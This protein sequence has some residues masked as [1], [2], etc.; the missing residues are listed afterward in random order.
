VR[1]VVLTG[2]V[3]LW[4][5][6]TV[7]AEDWT[8]F[9]G[10]DRSGISTATGLMRTFPEGG[11][12][13][14]WTA[15]VCQGYAGPAVFAGEVYFNDYDEKTSVW[16]VRCLSLTDGQEQWRFKEPREIRANHGIT[17]TVPA[18]DGK[19]VFSLDP[20]CGFHCL[21]ASNGLELWSKNLVEEYKAKIP[22]WYNGQCP[23]IEPDR[24]L[25]ATGGDALAVAFEKAT[26][27]EIWRTPNPD[28]SPMSHVSLMPAEIGGVKQY[29]YCTLKAIMGISAADGKLLWS[30]PWKFNL[31]VTPSPVAIGD[32][33]VF[34]TSLYN[35]DSVMIR[36]K[37][38]GD[39]WD[40]EK[41]F[42]LT[43]SEWN[44]EVHTP[45][46][47]KDRLFAVGKKSRGLFT[48]L[49]LDGKIVWTS[50]GKGT[51]GLGSFLL[52]DG[53]FFVLDG[54]TGM[55]RLFEAST[56]ECK[57]LAHAQVLS[58]GDVWAPMALSDGKLVLR[59]MKKM[60]CVE[61][62]AA[63]ASAQR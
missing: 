9:R 26:G 18:V 57:E 25:I 32:G 21:E 27:K 10:P 62:K 14:L 29:L 35:A 8:Q 2:F 45:I 40:V 36:V 56:T 41:V 58:G 33:R 54:D 49:D 28:K 52:A 6:T 50:E 48:C 38:E 3:L 30:F 11:P 23:L 44:A 13:V 53:M 37:H 12:K 24:V 61:V 22:A 59:D 31:S 7:I 19:Y 46:L 16:L 55:L 42:V 47:Y 4:A 17:R 43:T 15:N 1:R 51:F 63:A 5:W 39:N 60:V 34:I 20:K